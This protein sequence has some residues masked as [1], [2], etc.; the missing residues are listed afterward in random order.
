MIFMLVTKLFVIVSRLTQVLL[1]FSVDFTI[2]LA[3]SFLICCLFLFWF[4]E[5]ECLILKLITNKW[6]HIN[7]E[8]SLT[9]SFFSAL[10]LAFTHLTSEIWFSHVLERKFVDT[11]LGVKQYLRFNRPFL[12]VTKVSWFPAYENLQ[13][14][15][16][17]SPAMKSFG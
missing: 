6:R 15:W 14:C 10:W 11:C 2:V 13:W 16:I 12:D 7:H 1:M 4:L 3:G 8:S 17:V 9:I 5:P